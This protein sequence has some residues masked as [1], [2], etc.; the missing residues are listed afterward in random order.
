MTKSTKKKSTRSGNHYGT[1]PSPMDYATALSASTPS[2]RSNSFSPLDM[3][4]SPPV[5]NRPPPPDDQSDPPLSTDNPRVP[6][7]TNDDLSHP[8][9]SY[10]T[11]SKPS[12]ASSTSQSDPLPHVSNDFVT[13]PSSKTTLDTIDQHHLNDLDKRFYNMLELLQLQQSQTTRTN[14]K[15]DIYF[16]KLSDSNELIRQSIESQ[17]NVF[18]K[19]VGSLHQLPPDEKPPSIPD[20]AP[21]TI[22]YLPKAPVTSHHSSGLSV[23]H[24][25]IA[26]SGNLHHCPPQENISH[27]F[28]KNAKSD[29]SLASSPNIFGSNE[30]ALACAGKIKFSEI[31]SS[32]KSKSLEDDSI[33][34]LEKFYSSVMRSVCY[35]FESGIHFLPSFLDL[36]TSL[37]F[38][39][40]FL[41]DLLGSNLRKCDHVYTRIGEIIKDRLTN[42]ECISSSTSPKAMVIIQS[43]P[44]TDGWSLLEKL[45]RAR[46]VSCGAI[47]DIDLDQLRSSLTWSTSESLHDFYS[48]NQKL[49][50]AYRFRYRD[51][52]AI[53]R[54]KI[55]SRFLSE[56][57]R[58]SDYVPYLVPYHQQLIQHLRLYGDIHNQQHLPFSIEQIYELLVHAGVPSTPS[59]LRPTSLSS[60]TTPSPSSDISSSIFTTSSPH[61]SSPVVASCEYDPS[62]CALQTKR[63][64]CQVCLMGFHEENDCY[65]RGKNFIDPALQRRINIYNQ[66]HGDKPPSSHKVKAWQPQSIT[67]FPFEKGPST[68][69]SSDP[70]SRNQTKPRKPFAN[71]ST[72]TK[73]SINSLALSHEDTNDDFPT[74][75]ESNRVTW[76]DNG[77]PTISSFLSSQQTALEES[78]LQ[79]HDSS[80]HPTNCSMSIHHQQRPHLQVHP[81]PH[82]YDFVHPYSIDS[83]VLSSTPTTLQSIL[84]KAQ[85]SGHPRKS[86]FLQHSNELLKLPSQSFQPFCSATFN[87]DSGA[88]CWAVVSK[89]LFYFY[90]PN[91][92][93]IQQVDGSAFQSLGWGG[94][95][96]RFG[97]KVYGVYPVHH[98]PSNPRNT[99]SPSSLRAFSGFTRS[100]INMNESITLVHSSSPLPIDIPVSVYNDMD[101]VHLQIMTFADRDTINSMHRQPLRRSPRLH[102]TPS[103][104][105]SVSPPQCSPSSTSST[106]HLPPEFNNENNTTKP[107]TSPSSQ[108]FDR[109]VLAIIA[110][111][112]VQLFPI[113]SPR[114]TAIRTMNSLLNNPFRNLRSPS[115]PV[116][117]PYPPIRKIPPSTTPRRSPSTIPTINKMSARLSSPHL[118]PIQEYIFLH[119]ATMH[120]S[121][122]TLAPLLQRQ[123]LKDLPPRLSQD[124]HRFACTCFICSLRKSD[125]IPRGKLVDCSLLA[126][127]QRLHIDFSFFTVK[128]IRGF[129]SSLDVRCAST[130]YPF[131]FPTKNKN[132]PLEAVR[133]LI[134]TLRSQ[135]F[136]V[137][138]IR[139]DEDRALAN[140]SE[141]CQ[142]I[143]D[144][145]CVLETTAG[146][147]SENNGKVERGNRTN[148]NMVRSALTTLKCILVSRKVSISIDLTKLWCFA[149]QHSVYIQR[150]MYNRMRKDI[151]Y[152]LVFGKRP[153]AKD[154]VVFGSLVTVVNPS[155][156]LLPK[157]SEDRATSAYFIGFSNHDDCRIVWLP[158]TPDRYYR[159]RH[160]V[161][162]DI[163]T[164]TLLQHHFSSPSLPSLSTMSPSTSST[165]TPMIITPQDFDTTD[166]KF[167]STHIKT[168]TVQLPPPSKSIGFTIRD[169]LLL[170]IPFIQSILPTSPLYSTFPPKLRR[171]QFI[172]AI[173]AESPITATYAVAVLKQIQLSPNRQA[174]FSLVHRVSPDTTTSLQI[175]RA[176]FD[177]LPSM[178]SSKPIIGSTTS[179]HTPLIGS[180]HVP[181]SHDHFVTAPR[182]P[183]V[184]K[185][186]YDA[187]KSPYRF[188]W[189]AA[190]W[191]QFQKNQKIAV[192]SLPIPKATLPPD[193]RVFRSQLVP[194][195]K[196]TDVPGIFELKVRDV[197]CGTPQREGIDFQESYSPVVDPTTIRLQIAFACCRNYHI[198]TIDVKNAFQ[199]TIAP[200]ESRIWVTL[201]P[202]Y[203]EWLLATENL[204]LDRNQT[205]VR[206]M[207][208]ANQGTKDAGCLWYKLF[209]SVME[210]YGMTRSTVDHAFFI[211]QYDDDTY[212]SMSLATDDLLCSFQS[213]KHFEDLV[214]FLRQYFTLTIHT[215]PVIKFLGIRF[216]QSDKGISMDQAEYIYDMLETYFGQNVDKI[217]TASNPMRSDND[218]EKEL[219]DAFPLSANELTNYSITYKGSYRF[220]TGK[221]QFVSSQTR[222]DTL[223][224][225]QR[226]AEFNNA[227]SA[228][229]FQMIARILRYFAKDVLRPLMFPRGSIQGS[230]NI[231]YFVTPEHSMN[232]EVSNLPT[233]FTDAELAR[234]LTTRK[235]YYCTIIV[236]M[237]VIV[238]MKVKKTIRIMQHTTDSELHGAFVGVRYL[239]PIRQLCAFMGFPLGK[240]TTLH[241]DNA[242]VEAIIKSDRVTPRCRHIDIPIAL[243]Q[244]EKDRDY[245]IDLTKTQ[246][247]LADM[248]SKPCKTHTLQ[249]FKYWGLGA[250]FLPP[251]GHPHYDMLELQFYEK[252]FVSIQ[253]SWSSKSLT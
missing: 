134:T 156:H 191:N 249:R 20:K 15:Q 202:T 167:P 38:R 212:M 45:L 174:T 247:M 183:D 251:P 75:L 150:R 34:K 136:Q 70:L 226:C 42:S 148:A 203:I 65:L 115:P 117:L 58:A 16:R 236:V 221:L 11:T 176:M 27:N 230:Q 50:T 60:S 218:L 185:S 215:G 82:P 238:Q 112:Y 165:L 188:H 9:I 73:P 125:K 227:P 135:G 234:D 146:G 233:L 62:I 173:N 71:A 77:V 223:F 210:K 197:I 72:K 23:P 143:V 229:S 36:D 25:P 141:F 106:I 94:I 14:E 163:S 172:I 149:L 17:N 49:I 179:P 109:R 132:A 30:F 177:N 126:P 54:T 43:N 22:P 67:P 100:I 52:S 161:I 46:V 138:F 97:T 122:S 21:N 26:P 217:K 231:S 225:T 239:K 137:N 194:E 66:H 170:N 96:V 214:H 199:N 241:V 68:Q 53:P 4:P 107:A 79:E 198:A 216:I 253:Q 111:F 182:K 147:H 48:R 3:D 178:V 190:A 206:Q 196:P 193:S 119:L 155:K 61:Q 232:L 250:R 108:I 33:E 246:L 28:S 86:F 118:S 40:L 187:L 131:S 74:D 189:K 87:S 13:V 205:Y 222:F 153:S 195:I 32:L 35:A 244:F 186:F 124:L 128:S 184:P 154:L 245:I 209:R 171:N 129:T 81:S 164:Y 235:S 211:K 140:S 116:H 110:S 192:F 95:L 248:G 240:P 90:I 101:F 201:P 76:D 113:D 41:H 220:W 127:F 84:S 57:N 7:T 157:L 37:D 123:L 1:T 19:L 31:E 228:I 39:S 130:S 98:C 169:D 105:P 89:S 55:L 208:N 29:P 144:L 99:F 181:S 121:K 207:L 69:T 47:P 85:S 200:P 88:N 92:T 145:H 59:S 6:T 243:L 103:P 10:P 133:Y 102:Q 142:L 63:R 64:R 151:P 139:V 104:S 219:Y 44:T 8:H 83:T 158:E 93:N 213:Y 114:E 80:F 18:S 159:A 12:S 56:L 78:D 252:T 242:A 237:N 166:D 24:Q 5:H 91:K 51:D 224:A 152:F 204:N 168:I 175:N 180:I 120:S 160:C 2:A 162:D